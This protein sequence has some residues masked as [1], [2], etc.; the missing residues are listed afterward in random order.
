MLK[1]SI[2]V[3]VF[4]RPEEV[5][6]FLESIS[7]QSFREFELIM[8]DGSPTDLLQPVIQRFNEAFLFK[9]IYVKN[10]GASE[11]RN[12]G[13]ENATGEYLVFID[14]DCIVPADYLEK[15]NLFLLQNKTDG[16]GGPDAADDSFSPVQKAINYAMTSML[17]T[18]GI[19]GKKKHIGKYQLRGFN[20]GIKRDVFFHVGGFSGM[21]VA[22]DIDLSMRLH[23]AG[24]S[25]TLI[26]EAFVYH[27]RKTNFR[28]FYKQLF[29]HGK[30]R[31][32]LYV[33]HRDALKVVHLI[34]TFF[35]IGLIGTFL[36]FFVNA[37]LFQVAISLLSMY[38][39]CILLHAV[40]FYQNIF[41]GILSVYASFIMLWA[42]GCG[43]M[44]NFIRRIIFKK[45]SDSQKSVILK[46]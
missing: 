28:K 5:K 46:N 4:N 6:E 10:L 18:G 43:L 25:T 26:S 7:A 33:R 41:T 16:F 29:M 27:K 31:I 39:I 9:Y 17:T 3:P 35:V 34:P 36:F 19:R 15:I 8:V 1:F 42:Y 20:M 44:I 21:Q 2:I 12:L 11:S 38:F 32:D 14:S 45:G 24:Y 30:G 23:K 13:C 37:W 22:E 40:Y